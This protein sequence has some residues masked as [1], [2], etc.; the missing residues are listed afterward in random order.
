MRDSRQE[1]EGRTGRGREEG[2][3]SCFLVSWSLSS[4]QE[5]FWPRCLPALNLS[6][7][8]CKVGVEGLPSGVF[9]G[10]GSRHLIPSP[11]LREGYKQALPQARLGVGFGLSDVSCAFIIFF[12]FI[13]LFLVFNHS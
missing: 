12:T 7:L 1:E 4:P 13:Y 6:L 3:F 8:L 10:T 5:R 9:W 2:K 11:I